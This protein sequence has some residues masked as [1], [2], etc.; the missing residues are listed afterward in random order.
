[1]KNLRSY[2]SAKIEDFLSQSDEEILGFIEANDISA[3]TNIL[4]R[5]TWKIEIGILKHQLAGIRNARIIF[6]YTIPRMGKRIDAV[7]LYK[8]IVF[9]LEFKCGENEYTSCAYD[10]VF[11]Y[12]LD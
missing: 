4:Q 10:Q 1:M 3:Q 12:A 11:D 2:Y 7:L 8:N 6:E 9:L 5:N